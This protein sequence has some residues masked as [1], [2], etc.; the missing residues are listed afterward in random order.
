MPETIRPKTVTHSGS[1]HC[2]HCGSNDSPLIQYNHHEHD[3]LTNLPAPRSYVCMSCCAI[4][5]R[6]KDC[7]NAER[8]STNAKT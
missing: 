7:L 5:A 2:G 6:H 3:W 4:W 8:R 1:L